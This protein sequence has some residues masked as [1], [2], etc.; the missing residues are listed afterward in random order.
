M[1]I[2]CHFDMQ[3]LYHERTNLSILLYTKN[4]NFRN[5]C[6]FLVSTYTLLVKKNPVFRFTLAHFY[7]KADCN[8]VQCDKAPVE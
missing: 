8:L 7:K 5:S 2:I 1:C 6:I 4:R 3:T